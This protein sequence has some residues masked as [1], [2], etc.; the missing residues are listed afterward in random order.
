MQK[1]DTIVALSEVPM[2]SEEVRPLV[3]WAGS[4]R[5]VVPMLRELVPEAYQRYVEP[6]AGSMCLCL[7]LQPKHAAINDLN[8][9]LVDCYKVV[10][11]QPVKVHELAASLPSDKETYYRVR[12]QDVS[13][14]NGIERAARFLYLNRNCFNGV[15]RTDKLGR[16]N[17]P[18]GRRTGALPSVECFEEFA[19]A[20]AG[21]SFTSGDF[22][23]FCHKCRDGDFVYLDPPYTSSARKTT[24]EY[25]PNAFDGTDAPRLFKVLE[26]MDSKGVKFLLSYK[27]DVSLREHCEIRGW[28]V[29]EYEAKRHMAGFAR[30]REFATE[31]AVMNYE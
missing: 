21:F 17:V 12:A 20:V 7:A 5:Q 24:G 19:K 14:L 18:I 8:S 29:K 27:S 30:Y 26:E 10:R 25:G 13:N 28:R 31:L 16:F 9:Q 3:R 6:F 22:E 4:K 1:C 15:Y 11:R 23:A 2:S